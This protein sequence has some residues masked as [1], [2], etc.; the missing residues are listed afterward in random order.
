MKNLYIN[1]FNPLRL[2]A[3]VD[4]FGSVPVLFPRDGE[5]GCDDAF[6]RFSGVDYCIRAWLIVLMQSCTR[7]DT[8]SISG[9]ISEQYGSEHVHSW[10]MYIQREF[11]SRGFMS[12]FVSYLRPAETFVLCRC[13][14]YLLSRFELSEFV[15]D[16]GYSM[17]LKTKLIR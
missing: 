13:L 4:W 15:F 3:S 2:S 12:D 7:Y 17:F 11:R 9:F 6:A 5:D 14:C 10:T 16:T 8:V 1:D